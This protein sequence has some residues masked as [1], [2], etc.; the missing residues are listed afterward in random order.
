MRSVQPRHHRLVLE[1]DQVERASSRGERLVRPVVDVH[2]PEVEILTVVAAVGRLVVVLEPVGADDAWR[3]QE[4][5]ECGA[6]S[7]GAFLLRGCHRID[8]A[9]VLVAAAVFSGGHVELPDEDGLSRQLVKCF[10]IKPRE[11]AVVPARIEIAGNGV[12]VRGAGVSHFWIV[13]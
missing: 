9:I 3:P 8:T 5:S 1:G 12:H 4:R 7:G 2:Q 6:E 11:P 10:Q 13:E